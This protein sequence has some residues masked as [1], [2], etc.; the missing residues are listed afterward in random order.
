MSVKHAILTLLSQSPRHRYDLKVSFESMVHNQWDL[1]AGQI[2]TT[3]DR[4][5]R[6]GLVQETQEEQSELKIYRT[7]EKG[8]AEVQKWLLEPVQASLLQ[9]EF[10]FKMLCAKELHFHRLTEMIKQHKELIIKNILKLQQL[11]QSIDFTEENEAIHY[12]I[13][14]RILHLEADMKWIDMFPYY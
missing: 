8:L 6:D 7:T 2:Y 10:F 12:L 9:D 14:G 13:D 4:L 3:I 5:I 11:R 1:N